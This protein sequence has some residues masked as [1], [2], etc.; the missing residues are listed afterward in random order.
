MPGPN[1]APRGGYQ[2]PK[3]LKKTVGRP[4]G[5]SDPQQAAPAGGV[6]L[7]AGVGVRQHRRLLY[8]AGH[9]QR[10]HLVGLHRLRRP[11]PGHSGPGGR[12]PGGLSGHLQP[13][14]HHGP[15]GPAGGEPPAQRPCLTSCR[16]SPLSYFDKHPPR[17]ADEPLHQRRGQRATWPWSRAWSPCAPAASCLWGW[18]P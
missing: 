17:R 15:P 11:G 18:W 14:G 9:H 13:V 10:L 6:W 4:A 2:K 16:T 3:D 1:R 8:D 12:V 7:P 5:L